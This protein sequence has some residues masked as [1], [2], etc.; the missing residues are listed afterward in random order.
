MQNSESNN[1]VAA[2]DNIF[3]YISLTFPD[4]TAES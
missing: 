1:A 2:A 4:E 3:G